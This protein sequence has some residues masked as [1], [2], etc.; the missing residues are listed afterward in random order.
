MA[1]FI[2][3]QTNTRATV[4]SAAEEEGEIE[5]RQHPERPCATEISFPENI[6]REQGDAE[7]GEGSG[8]NLLEVPEH[9][10]MLPRRVLISSFSAP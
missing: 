1:V 5:S 7:Q 6:G 8:R 3:A 9:G 10:L 4:E 2:D